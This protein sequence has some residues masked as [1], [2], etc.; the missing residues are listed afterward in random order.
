MPT[1]S[2]NRAIQR[3]SSLGGISGHPEGAATLRK[4]VLANAGLWK[5]TTNPE[6]PMTPPAIG[7]LGEVK[8]PVL[9]ILGER[10]LPDSHAV[11]D[12]LI[13]NVSGA[14][15]VVIPGA[16]HMVSLAAP[17]AFNEALMGFLPS[18]AEGAGLEPAQR[19]TTA[20]H[21]VATGHLSDSV[22]PPDRSLMGAEGIEPPG[23]FRTTGLQPV[24]SP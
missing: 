10:D 7:R 20:G 6:K 4:L 2:F 18:V 15:K 13:A 8:V 22:T 3:I 23:Y 16:G 24:P 19:H 17:A 5:L 9:V 12:L 21:R 14:R 11:A 1:R